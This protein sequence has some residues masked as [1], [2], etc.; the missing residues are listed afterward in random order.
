MPWPTKL[1][2]FFKKLFSPLILESFFPFFFSFLKRWI[3]K[4]RNKRKLLSLGEICTSI[5]LTRESSNN[6]D[7]FRIL[8]LFLW[9]SNKTNK[10]ALIHYKMR[11]SGG[12]TM[13]GEWRTCVR[14]V[15]RWEETIRWNIIYATY[16]FLLIYK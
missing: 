10:Y 11:M 12:G 15:W 13:R 1:D 3:I 4:R 16:Y 2:T 5:F 6:R 8:N 7:E 14:F 9:F